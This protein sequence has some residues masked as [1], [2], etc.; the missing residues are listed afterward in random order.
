[1]DAACAGE[2]EAIGTEDRCDTTAPTAPTN[3]TIA[4][5]HAIAASRIANLSPCSTRTPAASHISA[6]LNP[7]LISFKRPFQGRVN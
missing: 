6:Q 2:G 1:V 5:A 7:T 3:N 4:S